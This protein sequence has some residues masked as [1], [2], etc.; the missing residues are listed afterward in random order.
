MPVPAPRMTF[1][2][3]I[4]PHVGDFVEMPSVC[5]EAF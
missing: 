5:C 3:M 2:R 1:F 4:Q